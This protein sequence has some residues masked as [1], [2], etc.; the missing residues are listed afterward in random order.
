MEFQLVCAGGILQRTSHNNDI[1]R[2]KTQNRD[3]KCLGTTDTH[4]LASVIM[5]I[6]M[7]R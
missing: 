6:E 1:V 4:K 7:Y 3:I 5:M 2:S